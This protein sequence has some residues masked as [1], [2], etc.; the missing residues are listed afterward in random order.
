MG[1]PVGAGVGVA[2]GAGVRVL[3]GALARTADSSSSS[4]SSSGTAG[5]KRHVNYMI[6]Y[7]K[8][9][10][11]LYNTRRG[12]VGGT[13]DESGSF[14]TIFGP[15]RPPFWRIQNDFANKGGEKTNTHSIVRAK[16]TNNDE[17]KTIRAKNDDNQRSAR[18]TTTQLNSARKNDHKI[19]RMCAHDDDD[20]RKSRDKL[21]EC[22]RNTNNNA[23][24]RA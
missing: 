15:K 7:T 5:G 13:V 3:L 14:R 1:A 12:W 23:A 20:A 21:I 8:Y 10:M 2:V 6:S 11:L 18:K 9:S 17:F 4:S 19:K 24:M 16:T 22:A